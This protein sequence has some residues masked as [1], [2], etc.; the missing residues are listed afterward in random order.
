MLRV[1]RRVCHLTM[2]PGQL[3]IQNQQRA[4]ASFRAEG[5]RL[6]KVHILLVLSRPLILA[7]QGTAPYRQA[8]HITYTA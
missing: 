1:Q 8:L 5:V 7:G 6:G 4:E 3:N 2:A